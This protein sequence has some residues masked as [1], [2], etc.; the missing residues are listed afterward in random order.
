MY[1][2]PFARPRRVHGSFT[3]MK[4]HEEPVPP[5]NAHGS[6]RLNAMR[7]QHLPKKE[8]ASR[9]SVYSPRS[10]ASF[11]VPS[12]APP[13]RGQR[14]V[15]LPHARAVHNR[16]INSEALRSFALWN[17]QSTQQRSGNGG[18]EPCAIADRTLRSAATVTSANILGSGTRTTL[19]RKARFPK[20][21]SR[22]PRA[23]RMR[24]HAA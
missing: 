7:F 12:C 24:L 9:A 21:R 4:H 19:R 18:K 5:R 11:A 14:E 3:H 6:R 20:P 13:L 1:F 15:N 16:R 22:E 23:T 17:A 10:E 2:G 8:H